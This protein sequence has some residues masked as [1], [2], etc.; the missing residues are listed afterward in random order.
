M[1]RGEERLAVPVKV[2]TEFP[3]AS[4]AR[5]VTGNGASTYCGDAIT[6]QTKRDA[7]PLMTSNALVDA[8]CP[9]ESAT[10]STTPEP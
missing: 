8:E 5:T 2:G 6:F 1:G 10:V 3:A 4:T 9:P 7:G